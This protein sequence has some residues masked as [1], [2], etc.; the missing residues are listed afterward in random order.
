MESWMNDCHLTVSPIISEADGYPPY[1]RYVSIFQLNNFSLSV[2][3]QW[4]ALISSKRPARLSR[5]PCCKLR[6]AEP[7]KIT[8]SFFCLLSSSNR[9]FTA[10]LQFSI[11]CTSSIISSVGGLSVLAFLQ[12]NSSQ[13]LSGGAT[14]SAVAYSLE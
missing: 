3:R 7:D 1:F 6:L 2:K 9:I 5:S 11:F 4:G 10:S 14:K 13:R 12:L 8:R